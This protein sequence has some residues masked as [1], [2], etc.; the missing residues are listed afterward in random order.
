MARIKIPTINDK[1]KDFDC[2]FRIWGDVKNHI[3]DKDNPKIVFDFSNCKFLR[4]NAVA[5]LGG[6]AKYA[7]Y[8]SAR[9]QFLWNTLA[10]PIKKNLEQNGFSKVFADATQIS[11]GNSV[12]YR[13]DKNVLDQK[14]DIIR[15]LSDDW[16]GHGWI[17]FSTKLKNAMV[18]K[19][20][21]IYQN[22]SDHSNSPVGVFSC[23]Q[24]FPTKNEL[25]LTVVDFG[26]GIP[27]R[28]KSYLG[29]NSMT[30]V[31]TLKWAFKLGNTTITGIGRG[32][33]LDLLKE[34]VIKNGGQLDVY[35]HDGHALIS[36]TQE[37]FEKR[38][39]Y[40]DGAIYNIKFVCDDNFY[41]FA[42]EKD[43]GPLF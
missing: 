12:P 17:N 10:A 43:M 9:I 39:F 15:Y 42:S 18:S 27:Y 41:C 19:T 36:K 11:F 24:R 20:W 40:F 6:M 14:D 35:S 21:E 28:V 29:D 32:L 7:L 1:P 26:V 3:D 13:E 30:S 25:M 37:K 5:F 23:G 2:L 8:N 4:P 33:G 22:A 16:L 38:T 31:E 34:F